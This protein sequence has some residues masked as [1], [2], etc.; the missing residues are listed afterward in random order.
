MINL[1][2]HAVEQYAAQEPRGDT[3]PENYRDICERVRAVTDWTD[4]NCASDELI[5]SDDY[6]RGI[7]VRA[8]HVTDMDNWMII[9]RH[10]EG[11][12]Q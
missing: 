7:F 2:K 8:V 4:P 3:W 9:R 10:M 5:N 11:K 1:Y 12:N 6:T